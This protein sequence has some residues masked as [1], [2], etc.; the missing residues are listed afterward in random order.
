MV[1]VAWNKRADDDD[2]DDVDTD[3]KRQPGYQLSSDLK[4]RSS[5]RPAL[6]SH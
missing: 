2:D 4:W 6:N 5:D 3:D 1:Q